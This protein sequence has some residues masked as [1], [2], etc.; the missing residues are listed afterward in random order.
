MRLMPG[1]IPEQQLEQEIMN[2]Q[3]LIKLLTISLLTLSLLFTGIT[4]S[5]TDTNTQPAALSN[6]A[7]SEKLILKDD[8]ARDK[9]LLL[10]TGNDRLTAEVI[11][12]NS[13]IVGTRIVMVCRRAV[14]S[15][16]VDHIRTS[17][18]IAL[19]FGK[20]Y[21]VSPGS[22][23]EYH[24]NDGEGLLIDFYRAY[25]DSASTVYVG[26]GEMKIFLF[27]LSGSFINYLKY[28][29][30]DSTRI[31]TQS[32]IYVRVNNPVTRFITNM[33]FAISDIEKG[34]MEKITTLD[35]TVFIIV[36]AFMEDPYIYRML[37][38]SESPAPEDASEL[39]VRIRDTVVRET[40]TREARELGQLIEKAWIEVGLLK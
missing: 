22:V 10:L 16:L 3:K 7:M 4:A 39:A 14:Y 11:D 6:I 12:Q 40:S 8:P 32:C 21:V 13:L 33:I 15:W 29:N 38:E 20:K 1:K 30:A 34:L 2:L 23:Y 27:T 18:A 17:A 19:I 36:N 25:S 28:D 35:D 9:K 5:S 37:K 24:G 31:A 26:T